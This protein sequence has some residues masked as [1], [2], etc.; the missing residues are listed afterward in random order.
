MLPE[1]WAEQQISL[2]AMGPDTLLSSMSSVVSGFRVFYYQSVLD[3][4]GR[5]EIMRYRQKRGR[6][7]HNA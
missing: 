5:G 3:H 2:E 7:P 6:N 4:H 1:F